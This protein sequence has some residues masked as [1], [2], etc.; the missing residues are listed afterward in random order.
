MSDRII[1]AAIA[2][3]CGKGYTLES[4]RELLAELGAAHT[5]DNLEHALHYNGFATVRGA[6]LLAAALEVAA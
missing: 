1:A 5:G 4:S 6:T 3:R 2:R